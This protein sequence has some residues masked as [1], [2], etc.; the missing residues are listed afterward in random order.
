MLPIN[1]GSSVIPPHKRYTDQHHPWF[2]EIWA[3]LE[4]RADQTGS[5][6]WEEVAI[7][8]EGLPGVVLRLAE[9]TV[10]ER[11][12]MMGEQEL[13]ELWLRAVRQVSW[14]H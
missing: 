13:E 14:Q 1:V 3:C 5:W 9:R 6:V 4:S 10:S 8:P 11:Q 7:L 2:S 12:M